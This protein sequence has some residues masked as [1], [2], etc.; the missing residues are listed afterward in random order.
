MFLD[1]ICPRVLQ[2]ISNEFTFLN[3]FDG[4]L[5][6]IRNWEDYKRGFGNGNGEYW[7]GLECLHQIT[8]SRRYG[9]IAEFSDF[10]DT[11]YRA[12]YSNFRIGPESDNYRLLVN[13]YY[14]G[15]S[16]ASDA[17]SHH[18]NQSFSTAD[19]NGGNDC[20]SDRHAGWW[21]AHVGCGNA[22]P[23]GVYMSG[24]IS[25]NRGVYWYNTIR[26]QP[27]YSHKTMRLTL[28]HQL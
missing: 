16:S 15:N 23:T 24:G 1:T 19:R 3:R 2:P 20:A 7:A 22:Q 14:Y 27:Y 25:N 5:N 17:L 13:G 18:N 12:I 9:L 6:F 4:S 8:T 26:G 11:V 10:N 28:I 21:Y